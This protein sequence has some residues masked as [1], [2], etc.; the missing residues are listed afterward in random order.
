SLD[1][2]RNLPRD[3]SP[4]QRQALHAHLDALLERRPPSARLD[5]DLVEDLR[6]QLQQ[7]PVAQRVYDRVKRQRLPKDV[8]DFRISDA[9]GR[10][11]PLVFARKSGKPLTDPLSGFFTYRGYR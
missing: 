4:E 8:P 9:A 11:A 6:R 10:D 2:E 1:W 7:L 5:Q 3:L